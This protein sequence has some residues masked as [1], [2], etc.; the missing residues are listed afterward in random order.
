MRGVLLRQ[1]LL[2]ADL[3]VH[4][5][6]RLREPAEVVHG[7]GANRQASR[8][9]RGIGGER[10]RGGALLRLVRQQLLDGQRAGVG[11]RARLHQQL[12]LAVERPLQVEVV[13][14][15]VPALQHRRVP[16]QTM[17]GGHL[18]GVGRRA[19]RALRKTRV[20]HRAEQRVAGAA[21][22]RVRR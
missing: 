10:E 9:G 22:E 17:G 12:G 7:L 19:P 14:P 1:P 16:G 13:Q 6:D 15:P 3:P 8:D 2:P 20:E 5:E 21:A 4:R 11:I 18:V